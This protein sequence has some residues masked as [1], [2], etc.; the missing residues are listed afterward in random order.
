METAV[1]LPANVGSALSLV[2][3][4]A[5]WL[6]PLILAAAT[7]AGPGHPRRH[8]RPAVRLTLLSDCPPLEGGLR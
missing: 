7:G 3:L 5:V 4:A 2:V 1:C 6:G 8:R